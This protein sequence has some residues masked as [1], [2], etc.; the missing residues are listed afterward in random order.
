VSP[1]AI[2]RAEEAAH[3]L[4]S[5]PGAEAV[6]VGR[7]DERLV[8][9]TWLEGRDVLEPFAASSPHMTFIMQGL[10]PVIS[11]MWS[12]AVEAEGTAPPP[13]VTSLWAWALPEREAVYEWQVRDLL[14]TVQ[15]LPGVATAGPTVEERERFRAGGAVCVASSLYADFAQRLDGARRIWTPV[16]G[17]LEEAL[18]PVVHADATNA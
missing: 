15:S 7:S 9:A 18:V 12:V 16:V 2:R 8:V 11:G 3:A 10:A 17:P 13:D 5:A 14:A 6:L 4:I 1:P